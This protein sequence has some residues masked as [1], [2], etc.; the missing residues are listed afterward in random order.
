[1]HLSGITQEKCIGGEAF[2]WNASFQDASCLKNSISYSV[3]MGCWS[4]LS[5]RQSFNPEDSEGQLVNLDLQ[6]LSQMLKSCDW[7]G[8]SSTFKF[9][10]WNQLTVSFAVFFLSSCWQVHLRL[11]LTLLVDGNSPHRKVLVQGSI[12]LPSDNLDFTSTMRRETDPCHDASTSKLHCGCGIFKV[13]CRVV[14]SS[15]MTH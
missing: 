15:N 6:L 4:I 12:N 3:Q 8:H 7:L 5:H 1:M 14:S 11:I 2:V 9:F 13:T 10:L